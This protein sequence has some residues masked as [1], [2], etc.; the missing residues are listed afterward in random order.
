MA[1]K[2]Y[3]DDDLVLDMG[4]WYKRGSWEGVPK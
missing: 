2:L 3:F 4:E 1:T